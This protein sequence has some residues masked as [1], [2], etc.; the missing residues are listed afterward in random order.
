MSDFASHVGAKDIG[1]IVTI[2]ALAAI[3]GFIC[4]WVLT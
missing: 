4:G 1:R 2:A 3:F